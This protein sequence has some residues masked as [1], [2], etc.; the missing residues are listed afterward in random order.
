MGMKVTPYA[1]LFH[2]HLPMSVESN[3]GIDRFSGELVEACNDD[4]K[5][6]HLRRTDRKNPCLTLQAQLWIE[7][8]ARKSG[9]RKLATPDTR[10]RKAGQQHPWQ[11]YGIHEFQKEQR[12]RVD[13]ERHQ[14]SLAQLG[15]SDCHVDKSIG[16]R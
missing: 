8:Q 11:A 7:L 15:K 6:T 4:V 12:R 16:R 3:G 1:H 9:I 10:K 13:A 14:A 5:R 2:L